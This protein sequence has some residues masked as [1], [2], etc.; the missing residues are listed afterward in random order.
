[1][2]QP[3]VSVVIASFNS[4]SRIGRCIFGLQQQSY[5][6]G[7]I[8][9]IV[10]DDGSTDST[11]NQ[12]LSLGAHVISLPRNMGRSAARNAGWRLAKGKLILFTDDDCV[13]AIDWVERI[14]AQF[15]PGVIAV[16]GRILAENT[17]T[18]GERYLEAMGYG[19]PAP[20]SF[21]ASINPLRR[22][23]VYISSMLK[24][25]GNQAKPTP[26]QAIF[27]ANAAYRRNI[28]SELN[29]FDTSLLTSEDTDLA[30]RART[31]YPEDHIIYDPAAIVSHAH[32]PSFWRFAYE[33][34]RRGPNTL[35]YYKKEGKFPPIYPFPVIIATILG[36]SLV[37]T[38]WFN[39]VA[40]L[41][42]PLLFYPWWIVRAIRER[43]GGVIVFGYCQ[44]LCES[45]EVI[46]LARGAFAPLKPTEMS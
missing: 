6:S 39:V 38:L 20:L 46:G 35:N 21:G 33:T 4:E 19:N 11:A 34:Y 18:I 12:A 5:D 27:T 40:V 37:Y 28:L 14:V 41:L 8:E 26:V 9:I 43:N 22:F 10:V 3:Y 32:Q 1:M 31:M 30:T 25:L 29:G 44:F 42:S 16:G 13:P 2:N 15:S 45:A 36:V 17:N 23:L 24:P 7:H